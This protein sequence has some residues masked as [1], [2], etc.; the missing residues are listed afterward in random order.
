MEILHIATK[1]HMDVVQM[2]WWAADGGLLL[3]I[4]KICSEK[5][6]AVVVL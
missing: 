2:D 3:N 5:V 1:Y 4:L 6:K